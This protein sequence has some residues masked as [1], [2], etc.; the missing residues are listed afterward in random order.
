M[1]SCLMTAPVFSSR[2]PGFLV[3][4]IGMLSCRG[5]KQDGAV[6]VR[7]IYRWP[8]SRPSPGH[9]PGPKHEQPGFLRNPTLGPWVSMEVR[10]VRLHK[11]HHLATRVQR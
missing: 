2:N 7:G 5:P 1:K 6:L 8:G 10:Q 3:C 9:R 4:C 11:H